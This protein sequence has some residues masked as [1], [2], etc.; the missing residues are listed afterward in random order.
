MWTHLVPLVTD[1]TN[2]LSLVWRSCVMNWLK[3]A[4]HVIF[5]QELKNAGMH[6]EIQYKL[7]SGG[8]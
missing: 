8:I 3:L 7:D 4:L 6:V 5:Q 2:N 1:L